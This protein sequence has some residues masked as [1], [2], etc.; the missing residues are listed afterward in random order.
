MKE[1][2]PLWPSTVPGHRDEVDAPPP[3]MTLF[4]VERPSPAPLILVF[5]GG[6]YGR[7]AEHEAEPVARWLNGMWISAAVVYYRVSPYRYPW[8]QADGLRAIRLARANAAAWQIDPERVGVLGFSAGGHLAACTALL[9]AEIRIEA[10]DL[11]ARIKARPDLLILAYAV[12]ISG[13]FAHR[14]SFKNLLGDPPDPVMLEK[15]SLEKRVTPDAPPSFIFTSD[16]DGPVP[17][18]NSFMLAT[19]LRQAKVSVEL[20]SFVDAGGHGAGLRRPETPAG[21]WPDLC[22]RWLQYHGWAT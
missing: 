13:A 12:L 6:G 22:R 20:H 14:G 15:L 5:P 7:Q 16:D 3:R 10:D 2:L 19:A 1:A 18:E 9:H 21:S 8:P 4:T 17:P 11:S